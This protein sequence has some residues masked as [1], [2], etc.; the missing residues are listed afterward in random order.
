[1]LSKT[2]RKRGICDRGFV[3]KYRAGRRCDGALDLRRWQTPTTW[4]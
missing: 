3:T 4:P 1:M 2:E